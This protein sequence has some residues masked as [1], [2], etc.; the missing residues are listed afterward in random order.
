MK[1][2]L[3]IYMIP[4]GAMD[5]MMKNSTPEEHKVG[6]DEWK[7][8]GKAHEADLVEMGAA[9]GKNKRISASGIDDVRNEMGGYSIIQAESHEAAAEVLRDSPHLKMMPEC[10]VDLMECIEM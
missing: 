3:A 5:E 2:F 9:L 6:M 7:A 8:W 4:I 1:K 10:Y